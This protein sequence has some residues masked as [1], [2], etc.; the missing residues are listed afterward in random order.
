MILDRINLVPQKPLA[1]R[2]KQVIPIILLIGLCL[3]MVAVYMENHLVSAKIDKIDK[4]IVKIESDATLAAQLKIAKDR[5]AAEVKL[6][7]QLHSDIKNRVEKIEK[8]HGTKKPFSAALIAI[9]KSIPPAVKCSKISFHKNSG[10][11]SGTALRYNDLPI[12]VRRLNRDPRFK[13]VILR[14]IDRLARNTR[15]NIFFSMMFELN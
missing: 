1:E 2:I 15:Q 3:A 14:D 13:K 7:K 10:E 11:I 8:I 5:L 9:A 12:I 4:E 6:L